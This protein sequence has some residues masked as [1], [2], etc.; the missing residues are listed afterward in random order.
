[1]KSYILFPFSDPDPELPLG[2]REGGIFSANWC[3]KRKP[4]HKLPYWEAN[5]VESSFPLMLI[6]FWRKRV[7]VKAGRLATAL[8]PTSLPVPHLHPSL[9]LGSSDTNPLTGSLGAL[10]TWLPMFSQHII[11]CF[12]SLIFWR[13]TFQNRLSAY[14]EGIF[15]KEKLFQFLWRIYLFKSINQ[16]FKSPTLFKVWA[17]S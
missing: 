10:V 14:L 17:N 16:L 15:F 3:F 11:Y 6:L 12:V 13:K 7:A 9:S 8:G 2:Y 1:M 5:Q 4:I